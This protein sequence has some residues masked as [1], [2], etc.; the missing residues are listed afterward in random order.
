M[1]RRDSDYALRALSYMAEFPTGKRFTA[2]DIAKKQDVPAAFLRK[3]FQKLAKNKIA[4]SCPG[5]GGGFYL[6]RKPSYINMKEILES[7]QGSISLNECLLDFNFCNRI[8]SCK[9]RKRLFSIQKEIDSLLT[10][11]SLGEIVK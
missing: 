7:V 11:L 1:I 2:A 3:I 9:V 8:K 4:S 6:A 10:G 5:P